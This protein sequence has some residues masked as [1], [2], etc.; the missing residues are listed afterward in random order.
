MAN[1][2]DV[3]ESDWT[4]LKRI[5]LAW[6]ES[7]DVVERAI[8]GHLTGVL[9]APPNEREKS[10]S[11][12]QFSDLVALQQKARDDRLGGA[13]AADAERAREIIADW[14]RQSGRL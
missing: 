1:K 5:I 4:T 11:M 9:D 6:R 14:L 2:Y 12:F 3:N 13:I 8:A 10:V 7:P